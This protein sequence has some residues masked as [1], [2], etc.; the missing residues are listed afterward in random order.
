MSTAAPRTETHPLPPPTA[1][2]ALPRV[3]VGRARHGLYRR[4]LAAASYL[5]LEAGYAV[6]RALGRARFR[7]LRGSLR[8]NAPAVQALD[9]TPE[10]VE[11]WARRASE[12]RASG[13]LEAFRLRRAG[14][15]TLER[16]MRF[17]G[18]EYLEVALAAGKGAILYSVHV[19]STP[20]FYAALARLGYPPNVVGFAPGEWFLPEDRRFLERRAEVLVDRF[21]CRYIYMRSGNFGVAVKAA[22]VLREN[23]VVVMFLD[24]PQS[25][26]AVEVDW[27]GERTQFSSGPAF[28]ARET[29][30][31]LL[32]FYLYRGEAWLPQVAELGSPHSTSGDLEET[33]QECALRLEAQVRRHPAQ[34]SFFTSH[35]GSDVMDAADPRAPV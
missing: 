10:R 21:H 17:E 13:E 15:R 11:Q 35:E 19:R 34:W 33:V 28:I 3:T 26:T 6:A 12:L 32:D 1:A 18:L 22:N 24:K 16:M 9:A 30:A 4:L 29:G 25:N 2:E 14:S 7:L 27:L 5:P 31:P 20:V 23:G 8:V